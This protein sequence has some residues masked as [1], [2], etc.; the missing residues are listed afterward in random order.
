MLALN[1]CFVLFKYVTVSI[2]TQKHHPSI[3]LDL[4]KSYKP[5][6]LS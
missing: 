2:A 6:T 3:R 1:S 5:L 4:K